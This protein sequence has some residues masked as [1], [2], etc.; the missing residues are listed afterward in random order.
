M[1]G[2]SYDTFIIGHISL[3]EIVYK[4]KV[5]KQ[6]GG[7]ALY[8]F[9]AAVAGGTKAGVL[10]KTSP[11][12]KDASVVFKL[13]A[14]DLFETFSE[15]S[16]SIRNEYLTEDRE[17]RVCTALSV[18]TPFKTSDIPAVNSKIYHLAGLIVGD[19]EEEIISYL[20]AQG[21]VAV[22]VQGFLRRNEDGQMVFRDWKNKKEL[23]PLIEYLKTDAVEAEIMTGTSDR[24]EAAVILNSWGAKEVMITHNEEVI[25]YS[26]GKF[27]AAPLKPRNLTG[28]TGRGDTCFSAYI[29]ERL[30]K[31]PAEALSYAAA[32]VSLKMETPGPFRGIRD[33]V[34]CYLREF[35]S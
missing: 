28:R 3:D 35:Y 22:D 4:G 31:E 8:C 16:T 10:T 11:G 12:I 2:K 17:K 25:V 33:D 26:E 23:L 20:A 24:R 14:E 13:S 7:A 34:D 29:T 21:K 19:F 15:T 27:Y 32:L 5:E 9:Y 1:H 30:K 6:L 18:A